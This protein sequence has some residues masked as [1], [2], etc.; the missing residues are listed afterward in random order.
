MEFSQLVKTR[1][2]VR[3]FKPQLVPH[4]L[5]MELIEAS[6]LAPTACNMQLFKFILVENPDLMK[7]LAKKVTGKLNWSQQMLVVAVDPAITFE[8]MANYM[9]AGMAVQNLL[10]KASD[11][12]LGACP[13]AGFQNKSLLK[14]K[15]NIPDRMDVPLLILIGYPS[16]EASNFAP[17]RISP[18]QQLGI[19]TFT[20]ADT[21][22]VSSHLDCWQQDQINDY[23]RRIS[24]VYLTRFHHGVWGKTMDQV[25]MHVCNLVKEGPLLYVFPWEKPLLDRLTTE[26][27]LLTIDLL[28]Y[29]QELLDVTQSLASTNSSQGYL[30]GKDVLPQE[31]YPLILI[32][33]TLLFQKDLALL[34]GVL[35][36]S[37]APHGRIIIARI[38]PWGL[39]GNFFRVMRLL[40][41]QKD[42]YHKSMFFRVGPFR[43]LSARTLTSHLEPLGLAIKSNKRL[44][45]TFFSSRIS[46]PILKGIALW[47]EKILPC[48][49]V[50]EIYH[51]N[52]H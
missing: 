9:S 7:L 43:L 27:S 47:A 15:L 38:T 35:K 30:L 13:L 33:C 39:L 12:G 51:D 50:H 8:N 25:W 40:G 22:P 19:N 32:A 42:V 37:L 26:P 28:D 11:M 17:Y 14:K 1:R 36:K 49:V 44:P 46:N 4:N 3:Q 29:N 21:F 18:K 45:T 16:P 41:F 6:N 34:L 31:R 48:V 10:L 5:V 20:F 23:R 52:N 2:S 24:S